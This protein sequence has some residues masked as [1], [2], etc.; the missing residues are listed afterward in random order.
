MTRGATQIAVI[1]RTYVDTNFDEECLASQ[2]LTGVEF[3]MYRYFCN[4]PAGASMYKR[5]DFCQRMNVHIKTADSA[6]SSLI[7]KGFLKEEQKEVYNFF[8]TPV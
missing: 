3:K 2:L 8:T 7:D 4:L 6:F 1:N 5:Q